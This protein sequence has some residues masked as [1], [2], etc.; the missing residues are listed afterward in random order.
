M[1]WNKEHLRETMLSLET[2]ALQSARDIYLDYVATARIDRTEPSENDGGLRPKLQ[3]TSLKRLMTH[4][5][6]TPISSI[7]LE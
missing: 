7:S 5:M 4:S 6:T 1:K 3:L 2:A